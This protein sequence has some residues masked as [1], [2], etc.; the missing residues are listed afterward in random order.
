MHIYTITWKHEEKNFGTIK[1]FLLKSN[2]Y[3]PETVRG[4]R[5]TSTSETASA[6]LNIVRLRY[7]L[8]FQ[9]NTDLKDK[10][11]LNNPVKL[12]SM[13]SENIKGQ[14]GSLIDYI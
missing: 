1:I 13:M 11:P 3:I 7:D 10:N 4:H 14:N 12:I 8:A 9:N 2:S 6:Y 5:E